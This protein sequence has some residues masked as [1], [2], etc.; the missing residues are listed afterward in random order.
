MTADEQLQLAIDSNDRDAVN[1]AMNR[2]QQCVVEAIQ[3]T[4]AGRLQDVEDSL[5]AFLRPWRSLLYGARLN[6]PLVVGKVAGFHG[7]LRAL[8][9]DNPSVADLAAARSA[10]AA[11]FLLALRE[12]VALRAKDV[13]ARTSISDHSEV[14][15]LGARLE[16]AGL[17][18]RDRTGKGAPYWLT[19]RGNLVARR[20]AEERQST[21]RAA[22]A[23][24]T[25]GQRQ[26]ASRFL[27]LVLALT[28][29]DLYTGGLAPERVPLPY[30]TAPQPSEGGCLLEELART[31][32][33]LICSWPRDVPE[34]QRREQ[35][36]VEQELAAV[37]G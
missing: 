9:E 10:H 17:V 25:V 33:L 14:S 2:L 21:M 15:H 29:E 19:L 34:H 24:R 23:A 3:S 12:G 6:K 18:R 31:A 16:K 37:E 28:H 20:L 7:I 13:L 30:P 8:R 36:M 11:E 27:R 22:R 5:T 26:Q 32:G 35:A 4:D 1:Q